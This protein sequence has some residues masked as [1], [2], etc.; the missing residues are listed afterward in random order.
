MKKL[1]ELL[2]KVKR[3]D[4]VILLGDFNSRLPRMYQGV[5]GRW[6]VHKRVDNYGGGEALLRLLIDHGLVAA[7]TLHKPKRGHTNA[8]Y[9]PRDLRYRPTQLDYVICSARWVTSAVNNKV[10]WGPSIQRRG[11]KFDRGLLQCN[12]KFRLRA[13]NKR[14]IPDFNVLRDEDIAYDFNRV[15]EEKLNSNFADLGDPSDRLKRLNVATKAAVDSLP[16]K[17]S[18]PLR[19][20]F[21]SEAT[22]NLISIRLRTYQNMT[23][24]E[25]KRINREIS[26]SCRNDYRTFIDQVVGDIA[27]AAD[28]GN[29][30][31][32]SRL[33]KT[34]SSSCN[35]SAIMSSKDSKGTPITTIKQ[36]LNEWKDLKNVIEP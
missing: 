31:E 9:I 14:R 1:D 30:R 25:R 28:T 21:I 23:D 32:V 17:K 13:L 3:S 15:V 6:C 22:R 24:E 35:P 12:W 20:R 11:R 26:R 18:R 34:I 2:R 5:T 36:L 8:T 33:I 7:S 27:N 29:S 10:R 4:C 16:P 19:K